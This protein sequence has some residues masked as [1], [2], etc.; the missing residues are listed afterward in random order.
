MKFSSQHSCFRVLGLVVARPFLLL[1]MFSHEVSD[2]FRPGKTGGL[3]PLE[4]SLTCRGPDSFIERLT[5]SP[6]L[7]HATLYLSKLIAFS[8]GPQSQ[9]AHITGTTTLTGNVTTS[10]AQRPNICSPGYDACHL[11]LLETLM[12]HTA[13]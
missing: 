1:S 10:S 12:G 2:I 6:R 9:V 5:I 4:A 11:Q 13:V 8:S 7:K 3:A